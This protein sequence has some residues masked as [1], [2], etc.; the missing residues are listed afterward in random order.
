MSSP[1]H[2]LQPRGPA[3][4]SS[5]S[6]SI[7]GVSVPP[8]TSARHA[9]PALDPAV[10]QPPIYRARGPNKDLRGQFFLHD[11]VLDYPTSS[12]IPAP[13]AVNASPLTNRR[14]QANPHKVDENSEAAGTAIVTQKGR[15]FEQRLVLSDAV[16][17]D[18]SDDSCILVI[19][20]GMASPSHANDEVTAIE[21]KTANPPDSGSTA[22]D[23]KPA[24]AEKKVE[25]PASASDPSGPKGKRFGMS[26]FVMSKVLSPSVSFCQF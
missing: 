13:P 17:S 7:S 23:P 8:S 11:E 3:G 22:K 2:S 4:S 5:A 9:L 26:N 16:M 21:P 12:S 10:V 15:S 14:K 6:S 1:L 25:S 20:T 18:D 19:D 24:A